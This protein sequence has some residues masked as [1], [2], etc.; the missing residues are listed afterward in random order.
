MTGIVSL[1]WK[2][3]CTLFA[4]S[5]TRT[6]W[7]LAFKIAYEVGTGISRGRHEKENFTEFRCLV[8]CVN[9]CSK[10][11]LKQ[12]NFKSL[13]TPVSPWNRF[14]SFWVPL[15]RSQNLDQRFSNWGDETPV[16]R[17]VFLEGRSYEKLSI[18]NVQFSSRAEFLWVERNNLFQ[19]HPS[20]ILIRILEKY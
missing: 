17:E 18:F 7:H 6:K 9:F 15:R 8:L 19:E 11:L 14:P 2:Q 13:T 1:W 5:I 16:G 4:D 3:H 12:N 10:F 20:E